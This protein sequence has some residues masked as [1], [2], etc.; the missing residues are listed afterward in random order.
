MS[1]ISSNSL[2]AYTTVEN[3]LS[4]IETLKRKNKN[5]DEV[6]A[7]FNKGDS[8][9]TNTKSS[10][11][12]FGFIE[13]G[14]FEFTEYG[15]EIAYSQGED[16]KGGIVRILKKYRPYE[17]FL[18]GLS[19]KDDVMQTEIEE[20]VNFWGKAGYGSTQRNLEDGA[21]LFMSI[22][23]YS[24]FGKYI[25]GRGKNSTRIEWVSN[26]KEKI[27]ELADETDKDSSADPTEIIDSKE[28][29]VNELSLEEKEPHEDTA[30]AS[31]LN[32][33]DTDSNINKKLVSIAS[34]PNITI[35]VDMSNWPEDKI[36]IFF[37]SAYGKFGED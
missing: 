19:Q 34:M 23:D 8:A 17:V 20:I 28:T 37:K 21:K 29:N 5:E 12:T 32:E 4:L 31:S 13:N 10:L 9:Y 6:K 7:I 18:S 36:K 24:K 27:E 14:S 16:K 22:I 11:R 25:I 15:R 26:I 2:P 3:I 30:T 33:N 35:S 1:K